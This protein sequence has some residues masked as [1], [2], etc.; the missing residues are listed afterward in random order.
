MLTGLIVLLTF[1]YPHGRHVRGQYGG[2]LGGYVV[3]SEDCVVLTDFKAYTLF[4]P[5]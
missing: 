5:I 2:E 3:L 1:V 4:T